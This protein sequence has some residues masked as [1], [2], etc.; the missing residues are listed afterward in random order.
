MADLV[1]YK[2]IDTKDGSVV[3][4]WG[5]DWG[6]CPGVPNPIVL[7][8]GDQVLGAQPGQ[9]YGEHYRLDL[10]MM[11]EPAPVVGNVIAERA[12]RLALGFDYDFGDERGVHHIGATEADLQGWDEVSKAAQAAINLGAPDTKFEIVT[13]TGPATLTAMEWQMILAAAGQHR[14]PIWA[15]SFALQA[16]K[17]IP[18]NFKED[19]YWPQSEAVKAENENPVV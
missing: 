17:E 12:R 6:R 3:Q 7:P 8:N 5:G 4:E 1:G 18:A 15:A 10:W 11:D 14:Q 2:L 9:T 19:K 16:L 13:D